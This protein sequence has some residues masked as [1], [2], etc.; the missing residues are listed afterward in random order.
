MSEEIGGNRKK[1]KDLKS[2]YTLLFYIIFLLFFFLRNDNPTYYI[3]YVT[4]SNGGDQGD[5]HRV[6]GFKKVIL[7]LCVAGIVL[8][9]GSGSDRRAGGLVC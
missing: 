5:T 1:M 4:V 3:L 8:C 6:C 2:Y 7:C 9:A